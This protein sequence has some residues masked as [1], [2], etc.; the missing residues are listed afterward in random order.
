MRQIKK[1][2]HLYAVARINN[3]LAHGAKVRKTGK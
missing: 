2:A 1:R 3:A